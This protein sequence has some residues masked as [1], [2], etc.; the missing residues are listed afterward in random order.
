NQPMALQ[1]RSY[2]LD[3]AEIMQS[4]N[5]VVSREEAAGAAFAGADVA[6]N[7]TN[8]EFSVRLP[9]DIAADGQPYEK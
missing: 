4:S 7:L 2:S 1:A 6:V 5:V 3:D 9:Q 8:T